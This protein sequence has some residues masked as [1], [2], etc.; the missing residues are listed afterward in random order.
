MLSDHLNKLIPQTISLRTILIVP[1]IIQIIIAVG[2]TGWLSFHHG[3]KAV[4]T[5]I[6]QLQNEIINRIQQYLTNCLEKPHLINQLNAK[7]IALG[8]L[9]IQNPQVRERYLKAQMNLL[10][11]IGRIAYT[12]SSG[13]FMLIQHKPNQ[14]WQLSI[15]DQS[16]QGKLF[17]YHLDEQGK[18]TE[19]LTTST[20]SLFQLKQQPWYVSPNNLPQQSQWY[21]IF[22]DQQQLIIPAN[23]PL[24]DTNQQTFGLLSIQINLS[25]ISQ[26]LKNIDL[27]KMGK[28]FI[29]ERNGLFVASSS[30]NSINKNQSTSSPT[31]ITRNLA[32]DSE[33]IL[34]NAGAH[35]LKKIFS[36]FDQIQTS[37]YFHFNFQGQRQSLQVTPLVDGRGIDWLIIV[38][39]PEAEFM[40]HIHANTRLTFLLSLIALLLALIIGFLTS[41]WIIQPIW[42][43]NNTA[44]RLSHIKWHQPS[45]QDLAND[46]I[47]MAQFQTTCLVPSEL[48]NLAQS[49]NRMTEQLKH[50]FLTLRNNEHKLT[51]FLEAMPVG[52]FITDANGELYYANQQAQQVL[53]QQVQFHQVGTQQIYPPEQLPAIRA[54][55]GETVAVDDIEIHQAQGT[56]A[57]EVWA[58][59]IYDE[60]GKI[61]YAICVFQEITRRRQ[62]EIEQENFTQQL[63]EINQAYQR[64]VPRE[65]LH[66]LDKKSIL[67]VHLGDQVEKEMTIFFSDIRG[68]T[69]IS[70]NMI[71]QD[72]FDFINNYLGQM[73]PIILEHHGVIDKYVGD[74]IMALFPTCVEDA[75]NNSIAMLKTLYQ[76]NQLL[77][78]TA[79]PT[80]KIGIGLNT[81]P[82]R[83]GTIGGQNRMDGTVIADAVN[84]ASRVE[85]LTKV[86]G[87]FLLITEQTYLKIKNIYRYRIRV[88]DRVKVKG[89]SQFVTVYEVFDADPPESIELKTKTLYA[90]EQG[91]MCYH[92]ENYDKARQFFKQVL[93]IN[94][95]DEAA[96]IY[97]SRC[98]RDFWS[99]YE[100]VMKRL[101]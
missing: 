19:Q 77:E 39:I 82:M 38:I 20:T 6:V 55:R 57:L 49:F 13:E 12:S 54:L 67:E 66:L 88:I 87:S 32:T 36:N 85:G 91:F 73:E 64:F 3:Q 24:Y 1:F 47:K 40:A 90:F 51:Q 96:K 71:P 78:K 62:I 100:K 48:E 44:Q 45:N 29:L 11:C 76:Y 10:N 53:N 25:Q 43:L 9:N 75:I 16:T 33:D 34:I 80:I 86:Y 83:V 15:A 31:L 65:F 37:Q 26:F 84:V 70:E 5:L 50:S 81:G 101:H 98:R 56:I 14:V 21:P 52:V 94:P 2:L 68:F 18:R 58:K 95:A 27:L 59:P 22:Q 93:E 97:F 4:D 92:H 41:H 99:S 7:A 74:A 69:S 60:Q 63:Y 72:I 28:I 35:Q 30:S 46:D 23:Q 8:Q 61:I 17:H 89:K 42:H 79:Y